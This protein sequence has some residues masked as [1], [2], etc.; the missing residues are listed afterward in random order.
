MRYDVPVVSTSRSFLFSAK[1]FFDLPGAG[2]P[3]IVGSF[4]R[5]LTADLDFQ[6]I[7][8]PGSGNFLE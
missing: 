4:D 6:M 3:C 8:E 5:M 1:G 7:T 2:G